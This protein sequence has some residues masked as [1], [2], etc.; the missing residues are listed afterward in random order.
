MGEGGREAATAPELRAVLPDIQSYR[1]KMMS[2]AQAVLSL[3]P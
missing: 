1:K 2:L 3:S